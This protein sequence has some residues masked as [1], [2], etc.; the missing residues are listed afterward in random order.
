[1]SFKELWHKYAHMKQSLLCVGLDPSEHT[2]RSN[3]ELKEN[4]SKLMW[5]LTL[6]KDVAPY[7][8][9]IKLNRN[10]YKDFSRH[11]MQILTQ[12]IHEHNMLA[13]DDSKIADIGDTVEAGLYH[14]QREGFDAVTFAPF[15]GNTLSAAQS[16]EKHNIDIFCLVLMSNPE[17]LTT[18]TATILG[19]PGYEHFAH[20]ACQHAN[21]CGVV[22]GAPSTKNH[23]SEE[24]IAKIKHI[25]GNRLV[26]MPG[27]GAQGGE[28]D[29]ML[30]TF[31]TRLVVNVGR[32]I[33]QSSDPIS[34]AKEYAQK[35]RSVFISK[36]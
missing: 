15:A 4:D 5:S 26:L 17:F 34:T 3:A 7:A 31:G 29:F 23:I 33:F 21:V 28:M 2:Q 18:K 20:E 19:E 35:T 10:Y 25:I 1:M 32:A 6:I 16:A 13:I 24:E 11:E 30:K 8:C 22:V 14:A 12:A 36:S 9:A 27:V